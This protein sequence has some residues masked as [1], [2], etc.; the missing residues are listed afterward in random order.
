[1]AHLMFS[2]S[3]SQAKSQAKKGKGLI[4]DILPL[5]NDKKVG[6]NE[7]SQ[8]LERRTCQKRNG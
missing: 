3:I 6:K 8:Y 7:R 1:M 2:P 5:I 4:L